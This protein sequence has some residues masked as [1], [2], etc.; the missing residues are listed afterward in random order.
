MTNDNQFMLVYPNYTDLRQ[1]N[2]VIFQLAQRHSYN[3]VNDDDYEYI[4][5]YEQRIQDYE[6]CKY[7][8]I[9][10]VCHDSYRSKNHMKRSK[11]LRD[12]IEY[13][14]EFRM[15]HRLILSTDQE[16]SNIYV[17]M[18]TKAKG[19]NFIEIYNYENNIDKAVPL[20]PRP[21]RQMVDGEEEEIHQIPKLPKQ[22]Q[23]VMNEEVR[24]GK[25]IVEDEAKKR[26]DAKKKIVEEDA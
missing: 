8:K 4:D 10:H 9:A 3:V 23:N 14:I 20:R 18:S 19:K 24:Y 1:K 21:K 16:R 7:K 12:I 17:Y 13:P 26:E 22:V 2:D 25:R 11:H 5:D 15:N 6:L